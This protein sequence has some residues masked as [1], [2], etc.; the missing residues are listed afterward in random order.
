MWVCGSCA[1]DLPLQ[2]NILGLLG[3]M[4]IVIVIDDEIDAL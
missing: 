1:I 4:T 2:I 3:A